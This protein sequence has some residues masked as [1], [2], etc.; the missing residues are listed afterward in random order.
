MGEFCCLMSN[1]PFLRMSGE[2][3]IWNSNFRYGSNHS[4]FWLSRGFEMYLSV[5]R[6]FTNA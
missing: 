5:P 1:T 6:T 3:S 2:F 4:D